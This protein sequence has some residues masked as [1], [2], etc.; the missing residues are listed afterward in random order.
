MNRRRRVR[1]I[2][3]GRQRYK[4]GSSVVS[5]SGRQISRRN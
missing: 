1:R 3:S 4:N 5:V 2:V